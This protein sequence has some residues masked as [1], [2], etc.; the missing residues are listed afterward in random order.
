M[1]E[2]D[3]RGVFPHFYQNPAVRTF[4][5]Q[6][7]WTISGRL[8][9]LPDGPDGRVPTRKAPIDVRHLIDTGRLRGAW[10]NDERC[11]VT[12]E[13]LTAAIPNAANVA[14]R[15]RAP[16]DGLMVL[17][18]EK[19]CPAP[20]AAALLRLPGTL[21]AEQ[22]MSGLGYHLLTPVPPNF[23]DYPDAVAKPK[24]QE[25]HGWWEILLD[26]WCTFTR[27]PI[28]RAPDTAPDPTVPDTVAGL[29]ARIAATAKPAAH[30]QA[31]EVT[32]DPPKIPFADRIIKAA[33]EHAAPQFKT[34]AD[35]HDDLSRWEFSILNALYRHLQPELDF[36]AARA[37][38]VF[39]DSD[40]AWLL[41]HAAAQVLPP[42]EK[43]L[44]RRN[45][46]PYLL[47]RAVQMTA[48]QRAAGRPGPGA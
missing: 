31:I 46:R 38:V 42:R 44:G 23:F 2:G 3:P 24:L 34:P 28:T 45:G 35:F 20:V 43:H 17:D 48:A 26:H 39:T 4:A 47:E 21:Y 37:R 5:L 14:F 22:S 40:I 11:L 13:E 29:Y 33:I 12:L 36:Y 10:A 1:R 16:V 9:D 6:A 41:Y 32:A 8:G 25:E 27:T 19:S 18:I 7:R 15:L 30:A